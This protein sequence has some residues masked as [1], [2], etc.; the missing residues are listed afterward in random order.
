[1][2]L[3]GSIFRLRRALPRIL[4]AL[5]LLAGTFAV[6]PGAP[7][8]AAG[9]RVD[10][11]LMDTGPWSAFL[12]GFDQSTVQSVTYYVRDARGR[13]RHLDPVLEAPFEASVK[14]WEGDTRGYFVVTAHVKLKSGKEVKDPGGWH[15]VRGANGNPA[16]SLRLFKNADGSTS[17]VYRPDRY[18]DV[19]SAVEFWMRARDGSWSLAAAGLDGEEGAEWLT[20]QISAVQPFAVSVHVVWPNG[21][22]WVDPT[23]YAT[24][25]D[26]SAGEGVSATSVPTNAPVSVLPAQPDAATCGDPKAHVYHPDRLRVLAACVAVSGYVHVIRREADGDDHVLL[27][28]DPGQDRYLNDRNFQAQLGDLVLEPVCVNSVTQADAVAA[29]NGYVNPLRVPAVGTHVVAIGAWMLDLDHGWMEL[30]PLVSLAATPVTAPTPAPTPTPSPAPTPTPTSAPPPPP[31]ALPPAALS[32]TIT[33]SVYGFLAAHTLPGATCSA[34]AVFPSGNTSKAAG[35]SATPT[36]GGDGNV[37]WSYGTTGNTKPGT[38]THYVSCSLNG[39]Q[40][41]ASAPFTV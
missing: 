28:L 19:I 18:T 11:R 8:Y 40:A 9:Q 13:W 24:T 4:I 2:A 25:I 6:V 20:P 41:T 26:E 27:K 39:Q 17:S 15:W 30:H 34:K 1:M 31:P 3:G 23:P 12:V 37:S 10:V 5:V 16:G 32:V 33:Q 35:L 38:G 36:A 22:L 7:A 21:S 29:C 14:W